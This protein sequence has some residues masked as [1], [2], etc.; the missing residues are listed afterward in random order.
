[1]SWLINPTSQAIKNM[2]YNYVGLFAC[3]LFYSIKN[4]SIKIL[5][6]FFSIL[7]F[8][9]ISHVSR[10]NFASVIFE[11]NFFHLCLILIYLSLYIFYLYQSIFLN[12]IY[13]YFK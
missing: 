6:V 11:N 3:W 12:L 13:S 10:Q 9:T 7:L 5:E 1:M 4:Y 2:K 8:E